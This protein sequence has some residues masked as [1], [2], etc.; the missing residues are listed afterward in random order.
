MRTRASITIFPLVVVLLSCQERMR[1]VPTRELIS[2][3]NRFDSKNWADS[4]VALIRSCD[5]EADYPGRFQVR[6]IFCRNLARIGRMDEADSLYRK[7]IAESKWIAHKWR[8]NSEYLVMLAELNKPGRMRQYADTLVDCC[9]DSTGSFKDMR[10]LHYFLASQLEN[11]CDG[12]RT[13]LDSMA[14]WAPRTA[15]RLTSDEE[16]EQYHAQMTV[17]CPSQR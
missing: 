8:F 5:Y 4:A 13:W 7:Y 2:K 11:D 6:I 15:M 14:Y 16:L 1:P 12:M 17:S 10:A 3:I 9:A